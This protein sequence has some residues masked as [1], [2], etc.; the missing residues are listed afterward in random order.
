MTTPP[1]PRPLLFTDAKFLLPSGTYAQRLLIVDGRIAAVDPRDGELPLKT[2][3]A[4]LGNVWYTP[5]LDDAHLHLFWIG[6]QLLRQADLSHSAAI[7][8]VLARLSDHGGRHKK[9]WLLGRG[10]DHERLSEKRLP[11]RAELDT[12]SSTRPIVVTR[13][14]GHLGVI[15]SAALALVPPALAARGNAETGVF[16][17]SA[18]WDVLKEVPPLT[19]AQLEEAALLAMNLA[20]SRGFTAVGT[21]LEEP[22]QWWALRRLADSGRMP[23]RVVAHL[24]GPAIRE[25]ADAGLKTGHGDDRLRAGY[26]K[27]FSDGTFGART[28]WLHQPYSDA[29]GETGNALL[30][31][32]EMTRIFRDTQALGFDIAVHAI[33]DAANDACIT[34]IQACP[35]PAR[36]RIEHTSLC[37]DT[38]LDRIA[39]AGIVAV[40]QPQFS[41]SDA[42]LDQRLGPA[43]VRNTY[44]FASML[45]RGIPLALSSDSPV[46]RLDPAPCLAAATGGCPWHDERLSPLQALT[47]YTAGSAF[48]GRV[49]AVRGSIAPGQL[50][51]F[52]VFP[53]DPLT[54]TPEAFGALKAIET[55]TVSPHPPVA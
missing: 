22:R 4:A 17:E 50:A 31:A 37:S 26:A 12:V 30:S 25:L 48:A 9:G 5:G 46:E 52:T 34:A 55:L 29:P 1:P 15:N 36:Q 13:V 33:G 43:R 47:A 10:F 54:A 45:R 42:W 21:M 32:A 23:I 14:C 24:P 16:V 8:E 18:L 51:D 27:F 19:E 35:R 53:F 40:V 28:A 38:A 6:E 44:R 39:A 2:Q 20:R 7:G 3:R 41:R 49:E 11:T